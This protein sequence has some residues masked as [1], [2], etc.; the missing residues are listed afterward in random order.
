VIRKPSYK[1]NQSISR[2]TSPRRCGAHGP[3]PPSATRL[4]L[5]TNHHSQLHHH[6][7]T[8]RAKN[9]SWEHGPRETL[10]SARLGD[11]LV[12]SLFAMY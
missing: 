5:H 6:L 9:A 1:P 11:F 2:P 10:R 4:L 8:T 3:A 12:P 7:A